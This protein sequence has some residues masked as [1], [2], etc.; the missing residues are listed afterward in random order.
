M[1]LRVLTLV[2]VLA[3]SV[4]FGVWR[5][6]RD[7][8]LRTMSSDRV[9]TG[10]D[11][12]HPLGTRA[13]LLQISAQ[14]CTPCRAAHRVLAQVAGRLP[15]VHHVEVDAEQRFDLVKRLDVMRTPTLLVLDAHGTVVHR[16]SGVPKLHE[17]VAA[18]ENTVE[19]AAQGGAR[20]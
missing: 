5:R 15:G 20:A 19:N 10:A 16:T 2:A 7:G 8:R 13:T 1:W 9:L 12:D 18:V 17:V 3:V 14:F 11:L 4:A 6:R